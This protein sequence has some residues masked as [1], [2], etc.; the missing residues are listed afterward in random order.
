MQANSSICRQLGWKHVNLTGDYVW[1][2]QPTVSEN[3]DGLRLTFLFCLLM[4]AKSQFVSFRPKRT[5]T[6]IPSLA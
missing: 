2:T 3:N 5:I 6:W 1:G 4:R